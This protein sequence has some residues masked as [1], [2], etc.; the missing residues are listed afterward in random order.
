MKYVEVSAD[1][2]GFWLDPRTYLSELSEIAPAL[3]T[4]ARRFVTDPGHYDFGSPRCVKDLGPVQM[5]WGVEASEEL[6]MYLAP[7]EWKHEVGLT[8]RYAKVS[9]LQL[10]VNGGGG[11][12]DLGNVLLDEILSAACGCTHEISFTGGSVV[13]SCADLAAE[14][15]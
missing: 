4:G 3:P 6:E 13:V 12:E 11:P 2:D 8:I 7:N 10:S 9:G 15:V 14:W 1:E 5:A